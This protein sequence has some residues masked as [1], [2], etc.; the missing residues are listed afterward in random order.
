LNIYVNSPLE[1][2]NDGGFNEQGSYFMKTPSIP[3]SYEKYP[4]SLSLSNIAPHEIFNPH[5]FPISKVFERMVVDIYIY[6]KFS[7]A[8][9]VNLESSTLILAL[10]GKLLHQTKP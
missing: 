2:G 4:D 10:E 9:V 8:R 1:V 7:R 5:M 3:C 6:H